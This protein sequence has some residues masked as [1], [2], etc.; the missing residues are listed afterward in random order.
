MAPRV[1]LGSGTLPGGD[2]GEGGPALFCFAAAAVRAGGLFGLV[3]DDV[4]GLGKGFVAG[5]AEVLVV[6]HGNLPRF[7]GL[8]FRPSGG[9]DSTWGDPSL[10]ARRKADRAS[11]DRPLMSR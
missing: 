1:P 3:L 10:T 7:G 5:F 9:G 6:G 11:R 8:D 4:Q 2:G